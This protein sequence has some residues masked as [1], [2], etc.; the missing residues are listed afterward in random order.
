LSGSPEYIDVRNELYLQTDTI[1]LVYDVTNQASFDSL[2][3]WMKEVTKYMT[4]KAEMMLIAN[5][6]KAL[7]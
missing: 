1:F 6:V 7:I 2:E 4:G 3:M 5:K